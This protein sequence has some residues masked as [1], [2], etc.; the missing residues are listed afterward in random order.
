MPYIPEEEEAVEQPAETQETHFDEAPDLELHR[1]TARETPGLPE[2]RAQLPA[3]GPM[4]E[5]LRQ[6]QRPEAAR[7]RQ[8]G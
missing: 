4:Q 2:T 5:A 8:S 1:K 3:T 7:Q 6:P